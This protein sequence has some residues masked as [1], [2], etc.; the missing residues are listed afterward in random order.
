MA[1]RLRWIEPAAGMLRFRDGHSH[2]GRTAISP[3]LVLV[4]VLG[5]VALLL[6]GLR[7]VR[8]GVFRAAGADLRRWVA[9]G[10]RN[11]LCAFAAGLAVTLAL[12]SSTATAL[13][14]AATAGQGL[15]GTA[16][17]LAVM[18]G[19]DVGTALVARLLAFDLHWL[20]PV[21]ILTG[22]ALFAGSGGGG[23]VRRATART[24]VGLGLV[25]LALRLLAEATQPVRG[26]D[27]IQGL[28]AALSGEPVLA[29][30]VA[31]AVTVVV[32]SSLA[33]VLLTASLAGGGL[34]DLPGAAALVLGA[35]LGGAVPAVL[36]TA[37]DGPAARRVP[38]GNLAM[39]AAGVAVALPLVSGWLDGP[40]SAEATVLLH[41]GFN[42]ALALL[43]LPLV[44]SA[45]RLAERA[46]PDADAGEEGPGPRHLD[47]SAL[48]A[49]SVALA[50][51]VRETLRLGDL[52]EDMLRRSLEALRHGD[53][54]TMAELSRMDDAVDTLHTAIKLYL[55]KLGREHL[56]EADGRRAGEILAF[57]INLEHIG[58]VIDKNLRDLAAK[59]ARRGLRFAPEDLRAVEALHARTLANLRTALGIFLSEDRRM[60]R[61]LV[62][63]KDAV[64]HLERAAA[65]DHLER[66][67]AGRVEG[68][69]ASALFL[70]VMR[71]LKRINAHAAAVAYP[72]L[73]T[74]GELRGSRLKTH[75]GFAPL[76]KRDA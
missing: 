52:V 55:V 11:R 46:L 61:R 24:L 36:A 7:L 62:G 64:R 27:L 43:F 50:C 30:L 23:R 58:D 28:L 35:N 54:R 68:I 40:G 26:S 41:A 44:G 74:G 4:D 72:I 37:S 3:T 63:E 34:L 14:A 38:L 48:E 76:R 2:V 59:K 39:R 1:A 60:A 70:D 69:E 16:A 17:A 13:M 31:A 51:A 12:Q 29:V 57:A 22:G 25:L 20:S 75:T 66:M 45:G 73:E 47:E 18:L 42:A 9:L 15:M 33:T 67:R 32:H 21:L 19:A 8:T 49:P 10:T 65:E 56:D 6:W 5:A 53:E 71:D